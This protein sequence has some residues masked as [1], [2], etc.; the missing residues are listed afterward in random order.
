MGLW[1]E[2][3]RRAGA[4]ACRDACRQTCGYGGAQG[5]VAFGV[6]PGHAQRVARTEP[7]AGVGVSDVCVRIGAIGAWGVERGEGDHGERR[8]GGNDEAHRVSVPCAWLTEDSW[9]RQRLA[10][11]LNVEPLGLG[12]VAFGARGI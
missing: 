3:R 10:L 4:E 5:A 11:E 6:N 2:C 8:G 9:L 12:G 7:G 1:P